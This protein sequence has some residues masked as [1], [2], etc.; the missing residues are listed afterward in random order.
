MAIVMS[1]CIKKPTAKTEQ[2]PHTLYRR[3]WITFLVF[4]NWSYKKI[5][6]TKNLDNRPE[7]SDNRDW[8]SEA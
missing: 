1:K 2:S 7:T 6:I 5:L 8:L 3:Q 4:T